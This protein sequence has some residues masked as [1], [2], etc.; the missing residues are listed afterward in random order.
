MDLLTEYIVS[1]AEAKTLVQV[2]SA[3]LGNDLYLCI[4]VFLLIVIVLDPDGV[5]CQFV[6]VSAEGV[7]IQPV[8]SDV[9]DFWHLCS[10]LQYLFVP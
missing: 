6:P 4:F 7:S 2:P 9:L 3:A 5:G 8:V 1:L 10:V